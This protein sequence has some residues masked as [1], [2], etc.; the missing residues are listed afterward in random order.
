MIGHEN[1]W[2]LVNTHSGS[3]SDEATGAVKAALGEAGSAPSRVLDVKA[4]GVPDR[5]MLDS[6]GVTILAVFAGDGTVN[7]ALTALE[8]W[9]GRVLVLPGGTMNLMAKALHGDRDATE[10]ARGL[11][12]LRTVRRSCIRSSRGTAI[13]ELLAGPGATWSDVREEMRDG[14]I[15]QVAD[16]AMEA[17]RQSTGGPMVRVVEP[18]A[19]RAE[20]YAG[21]RFEPH[22]DGLSVDGYGA[23]GIADY[24]RQGIA[25]LRR[26]FREGPHDELG[27]FAQITCASIDGSPIELM[28]DGERATGGARETFSLAPLGVNLLAGKDG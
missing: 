12:A 20:G 16:R 19:G 6:A 14:A 10:I 5:T 9:V 2:L 13:I 24:V 7:S 11:A 3:N 18:V 17:V 28:I 23:Q 21:V 22:D 25:L 4:D 26:D 8:G 1:L 27:H 15:A